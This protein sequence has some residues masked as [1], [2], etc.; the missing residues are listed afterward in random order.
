MRI[1]FVVVASIFLQATT[2]FAFSAPNVYR[3]TLDLV[4]V[5]DD[6]IQVT[7]QT[8]AITQPEI[9]YNIPKMVPG[10]YSVDNYGRYLSDFKAFDRNG[11]LLETEQMDD[12]RWKI[13]KANTLAKIT[14]WADD[15]FQDPE[16]AH[17]I[18]EPTGTNI[19]ANQNFLINPHGFIGYFDGLKRIP[20]E[21]TILKPENFYG[22][23]SLKAVK[24]LPASDT[25]LVPSYMELV[26]S[27][28]MYNVPDTTVL[29]IG[30]ANILVSVY[31]PTKKVK[32][33]YVGATIRETLEAQKNYLGGKLPVDKYAFLIYLSDKPNKTGAYGALE[34]S[35]SSVYYMPETDQELISRQIISIAAHEFF[36]IVTPL[37]IH[38]E[39]IHDFDYN[40]PQMSQ[41]LWLYEGVTEYAATH[42]QVNQKLL[43]QEAYLNKLRAY[44]I[45][46]GKYNDTLPFTIMSKGALDIHA[47]Q[48]GNVYQKGALIGLALDIKLRELSGGNYGLRNLMKDLSAS[49]GKNKAFKDDELFDKITALTYPEIRDFFRKY[50]AGNQPLPYVDLFKTVGVMYQP[51]QREEKITMG[52]FELGYDKENQKLTVG[53]TDEMNDFGKKMGFRTGDQ[54]LAINTKPLTPEA[55]PALIKSEVYDRSEGDKITVLVGRPNSRGKIKKKKLQGRLIKVAEEKKNV[56]AINPEATPQQK[57]LLNEWLYGS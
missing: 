28:L 46:A 39:Q 57:I 11:N 18:F 47:N 54:L 3:F 32:A 45:G 49:Y 33:S 30:G 23:T 12:N 38:S 1:F 15:T 14:Y 26:D 20:Y 9:T 6:K 16:A 21:V 31:S 4:H 13:K 17:Q 2:S 48:Y 44:I 42:V 52:R 43:T 36:H 22:S 5:Q 8:P 35:Y 37:T 40:N 10:T 24:T 50:V 51:T 7:L 55:A 19:E 56:L 27:P 41:H 34:H 53:N 29:T 25:Y